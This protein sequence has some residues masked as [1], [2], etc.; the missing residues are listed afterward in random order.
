[1]SVLGQCPSAPV[2][3][4]LALSLRRMLVTSLHDQ[5]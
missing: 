4:A 2:G 3:V 5:L 1:M